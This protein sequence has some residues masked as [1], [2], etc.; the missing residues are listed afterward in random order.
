[1]SAQTIVLPDRKTVT[2]TL[3]EHCPRGYA[4]VDRD[5]QRYEGEKWEHYVSRV[6]R[7]R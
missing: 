2:G 3:I 5:G 1:M 6:N 7:A 4:V